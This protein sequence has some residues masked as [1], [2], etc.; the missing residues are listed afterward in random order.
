MAKIA[1]VDDDS[2]ARERLR[3]FVQRYAHEN[4]ETWEIQDF[5]SAEEILHH[6]K[7]EFD[8]I[9]LDIEMLKIDGIQAAR[10]IRETDPSTVL[11]FVTN[12]A[13]LAIKGYEVEALDF[14]V[15]PI[16]YGSFA[17]VMRRARARMERRKQTSLSL[18]IRGAAHIIA[19]DRIDYV[20]VR[21]HYITYHTQDGDFTVKGSLSQAEKAL[22]EGNFMKCNRWY[23]VNI[24]HVTG[25]QGNLITVGEWTVEV[26][27]SKKQEILRAVTL[28]VGEM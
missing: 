12:M 27:R 4:A 1:I 10:I 19:L 7:A 14:I 25:I 9:F 26:S 18:S 11:I 15:K 17:M 22:S 28:A 20:E 3:A 16:D 23:L 8:I 21:D 5:S 24:D 2:A 6:Y 13:Q